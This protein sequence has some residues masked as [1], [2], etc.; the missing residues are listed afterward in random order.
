M[1]IPSFY[2]H[3]LRSY[4]QLVGRGVGPRPEWLC[5]DFNCAMYY[6][7]RRMPPIANA[8][9]QAAW[10][11]DFC[12]AIADYMGDLVRLARPTKGAFVSCDG[13]VCAAKR[14][15]Q[16]L[17]RF[18]GPWMSAAE[19]EV[20]AQAGAD[21]SARFAGAVAHAQAQV[22]TAW[23]GQAGSADRST[24]FAGAVAHAQ[25]QVA[26]AWDQNALTPGSAFMARLNDILTAAGARLSK[27]IGVPIQVSTTAEPGEGEHKLLR[28]MRAVRPTSCT[29]YGL[30]A[31][32]IL[33]AMLLEADTGAQVRL[34]REA[35]EFEVR[36]GD[37]DA[38]PEW[39]NLDIHGLTDVMLGGGD[40]RDF[41][42]CMSLLGNDFLP[43]PLTRTV[44][45]DGIPQLI[46]G[47]RAVWAAG[48]HVVDRTTGG[49][50]R[51]GVLALVA[52]WAATEEADMATAV[53]AAIRAAG[54]GPASG[55]N[56]EETALKEW[57]G[58]PARWCSLGQI[59][60]GRRGLTVGWQ[61]W[62]RQGWQAGDAKAYLA[63]MAWVWDYYSGRTVDQGWCYDAHLPP[64]WCDL[65]AVL[66]A[67]GPVVAP[68]V[69]WP[70]ALPAWVHLLSVLPAAS[71]RQL[72]PAT[73]QALME[74]APWW[75]PTEWSLFDVGRGQMWECEPVIP[76]IP[77]SVL[78]IWGT[79]TPTK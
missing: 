37:P 7:L 72:L 20:R 45:D 75:W 28:A 14:R 9:S 78:R 69:Q 77:E 52:Q 54:R 47:L 60:N 33:L 43:R 17:R 76:V 58:Q 1:G 50:R 74:D 26:T 51:E 35:Q 70:D 46:A 25:A 63:G 44:R 61:D 4:P 18:K 55:A 66:Q 24:R 48:Q 2:R 62:Y 10:E 29:I 30:D 59:S 16:R 65:A 23:H 41:V 42:A 39:R 11:G 32:L 15:Q 3:L 13:V 8:T 57:Q 21:R 31:D 38:P 49:L 79:L 6:V 22:A 40:V 27:Q 53:G 68:A 71:V 73:A 12:N 19:A 36:K 67:G 5:L 56:P 34:L 64:L